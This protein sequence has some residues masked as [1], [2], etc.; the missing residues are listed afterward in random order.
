MNLAVIGSGGREHSICYKLKES[1]KIKKLF[2][3]P[4]NAGTKNIA[5]NIY[6]DI[7]NFEALYTIIKKKILIWWLLVLNNLWWMD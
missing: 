6:E 4:G 3:I 5:E 2:C 7:S 1:P